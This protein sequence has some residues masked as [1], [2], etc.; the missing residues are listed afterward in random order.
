MGIRRDIPMAQQIVQAAHAANEAGLK[1]GQSG[2]VLS[3]PSSLIL[4]SFE[5]E[6]KLRDAY[7]R[8]NFHGVKAEL[9]YEPDSH[10]GYPP[11]HTAFATWPV[12]EDRRHLFKTYTL[13]RAR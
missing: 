6:S 8:L 7:A 3:Q 9:F 1:S 4:L 11:G 10:L 12:T 5:N 2:I 13:W